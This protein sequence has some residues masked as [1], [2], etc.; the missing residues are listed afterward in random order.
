MAATATVLALTD[1][2]A[3]AA[4][5]LAPATDEDP[6][7]HVEVVDSVTPP[8]LLLL[9]ED[10]WLQPGAGAGPTMGPCLW[11]AR[12]QIL[13]IAARLEPGPGIAK[14]EQLVAYTIERM[15][16]DV[17]HQWPPASALAPRVF[18]FGRPPTTISYLGARVTYNVPATT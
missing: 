18:E 15:R 5:A 10:P 7:V 4:A 12:L 8:A 16:M 17:T 11:T 6:M 3:A 2:R 14:L 1:I 9:W 13:C